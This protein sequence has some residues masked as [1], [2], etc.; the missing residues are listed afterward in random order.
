MDYNQN[1]ALTSRNVDSNNDNLCSNNWGLTN[2]HEDLN[3]I[4]HPQF[5]IYTLWILWYGYVFQWD[6][7]AACFAHQPAGS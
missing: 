3:M 4:L 5:W 2:K 1:A 6:L 7:E